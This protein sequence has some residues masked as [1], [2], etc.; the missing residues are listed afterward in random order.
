MRITDFPDI[1]ASR[2]NHGRIN[3]KSKARRLKSF[4]MMPTP[5]VKKFK[6]FRFK[7]A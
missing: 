1:V 3:R 6:N 5:A 4:G 7:R 2:T